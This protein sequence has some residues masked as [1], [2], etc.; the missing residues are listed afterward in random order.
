MQPDMS[1]ILRL[2]DIFFLLPAIMNPSSGDIDTPIQ[3]K[4]PFRLGIDLPAVIEPFPVY[5]I[6]GLRYGV[7]QIICI[8]QHVAEVRHGYGAVL[9]IR[10]ERRVCFRFWSCARFRI[11]I[12]A[13]SLRL[14]TPS[15]FLCA[16]FSAGRQ[17]QGYS[18]QNKAA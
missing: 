18:H 17:R 16:I 13:G 15:G 9:R 1:H 5:C 3:W 8:K 4:N 11:Q 10:P 14:L 7:I 2:Y 12:R 6:E